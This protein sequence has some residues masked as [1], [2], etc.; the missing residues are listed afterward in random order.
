MLKVLIADDE[1]NICLMIQKIIDWKAFGM[2]VI[3]LAHNGVDAIQMIEELRPNVVITDIRMPGHD[4][5]AIVQKSKDMGLDVNFIIIS[6]Y[7]YFNSV[8]TILTLSIYKS[9]Y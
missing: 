2:E 7:K 5:L 6:G 4:G 8:F 3:G 1:K 9:L